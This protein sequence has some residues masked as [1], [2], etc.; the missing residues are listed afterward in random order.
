MTIRLMRLPEVMK[1][2]GLSKSKIYAL[3][4]ESAFPKQ[5]RLAGSRAVAWSALEVEAWVR[6]HL[7]ARVRESVE[8]PQ[9]IARAADER[10][11]RFAAQVVGRLRQLKI[12]RLI[13]LP[14]VVDTR[15]VSKRS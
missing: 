8:A 10:K 1:L 6:E 2:V 15:K 5:I 7:G 12:D 14:N 3:I 13:Q 9:A 4:A 11:L